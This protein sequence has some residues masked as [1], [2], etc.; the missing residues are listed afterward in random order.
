MTK[1]VVLQ[2]EIKT[3]SRCV[4]M[5]VFEV[6]QSWML[7]GYDFQEGGESD[8]KGLVLPGALPGSGGGGRQ[9]IGG[10]GRRL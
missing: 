10:C 2:L 1:D 8:R 6:G 7:W 3:G 4:L 9:R 5:R